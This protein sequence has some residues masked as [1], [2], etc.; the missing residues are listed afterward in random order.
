FYRLFNFTFTC[1]CSTCH[2]LFPS[3][4]ITL[5]YLRLLD[6][7]LCEC[8]SCFSFSDRVSVGL[9]DVLSLCMSRFQ[10]SVLSSLILHDVSLLQSYT[11]R[12][13]YEFFQ[14]RLPLSHGHECSQKLLLPL[15]LPAHLFCRFHK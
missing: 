4:S 2:E 3:F 9:Y 10:S 13:L 15:T 5:F 8:G 7:D 1:S 14:V 11:Y 12:L 6:V